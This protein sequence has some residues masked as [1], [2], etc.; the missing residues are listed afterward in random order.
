MAGGSWLPRHGRP[1]HISDGDFRDKRKYGM[2]RH[3]QD[4]LGN[5]QMDVY[6]PWLQ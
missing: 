6:L 2:P 4:M 3:L 5:A 1:D